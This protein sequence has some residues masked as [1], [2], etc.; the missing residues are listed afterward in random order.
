MNI[1]AITVYP[2]QNKLLVIEYSDTSTAATLHSSGKSLNLRCCSEPS[3]Q[4]PGR[5]QLSQ[6]D[7]FFGGF[8]AWGIKRNRK[9]PSQSCTVGGEVL[10]YYVEPKIPTQ[11]MM[12]HLARCRGEG[13]PCSEFDGGRA[14]LC[15]PN[16]RVPVGK[17]FDSQSV[18]L[19]QTPCE[20]F[21]LNKIYIYI[22]IEHGFH[23]WFAHS[24]LLWSRWLGSVPL[25][26]LSLGCGIVL[27]NPS[28]I[29]GYHSLQKVGLTCHTIQDLPTNQHKV[30][31]LFIRQIFRDQFCT[32]KHWITKVEE[33]WWSTG[34]S[35]GWKWLRIVFSFGASLDEH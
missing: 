3:S 5:F 19:A 16:T 34:L 28:L 2:L 13:T 21:T 29:S 20:Q 18:R 32:R 1:H 6:N 35:G 24:G 27:E 7:V 4:L 15:F 23:S 31:L 14:Q 17:M 11:R 12:R 22:Y 33:T 10:W 8:W 30:I 26:T 25:W 9:E